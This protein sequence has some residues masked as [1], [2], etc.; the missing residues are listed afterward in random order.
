MAI[1]PAYHR[2]IVRPHRIGLARAIAGGMAVEATRMLQDLARLAE[3]YDR[4]RRPIGVALLSSGRGG[5]ETRNDRD[6][7]KHTYQANPLP[8]C[9]AIW[10]YR[11][12]GMKDAA[13][14]ERAFIRCRYPAPIQAQVA[15]RTKWGSS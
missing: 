2:R 3:Q 9:A 8:A 11:I 15:I 14:I 13:R 6:G 12:R 4:A 10:R 5:E 1:W 7:S